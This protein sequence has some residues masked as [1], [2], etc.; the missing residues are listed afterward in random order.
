MVRRSTARL[1]TTLAT[2]GS[3]GVPADM[4][5]FGSAVGSRTMRDTR[6]SLASSSDSLPAGISS[7]SGASSPGTPRRRSA[8]SSSSPPPPTPSC[9]SRSRAASA[10]AGTPSSATS[11][12]RSSERDRT[13][14]SSSSPDRAP[15]RTSF[16]PLA[17]LRELM[18]PF[19]FVRPDDAPSLRR[20]SGRLPGP[21]RRPVVRASRPPATRAR[22][23]LPRWRVDARRP[24]A[25]SSTTSA[26]AFASGP[27]CTCRSTAA[28]RSLRTP[29]WS[30]PTP[31]P[32]PCSDRSRPSRP[33]AGARRPGG[34]LGPRRL[35]GGGRARTRVH[36][37]RRLLSRWCS[38]A[39]LGRL[40]GRPVRALPRA[41]PRLPLAVPL[42]PPLRRPRPGRRLPE[43]ARAASR[44]RPSPSAPSPAP[45]GAAPRPRRTRRSRPSSRPT[46][47]SAPST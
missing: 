7:R 3:R 32:R 38:P 5:L 15:S 20:R 9:S 35:R 33:D 40:P 28:S 17:A 11:R 30:G 44:A 31:S 18:D 37:R 21:R 24:A 14:P 47:R 19:E 29:R 4:S 27:R 34:R 42:L 22:P 43:L 16:P 2:S 23:R 1:A 39:A 10:G 26:T 13:E 45:G 36:R 25:P 46:R 8:P 6:M 41:P 12:S